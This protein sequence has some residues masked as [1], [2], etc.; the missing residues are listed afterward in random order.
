MG[1][2][3]SLELWADMRSRFHC[4]KWE[5][6]RGCWVR[7]VWGLGKVRLRK[8]STQNVSGMRRPMAQPGECLPLAQVMI[9]ESWGEP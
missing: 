9:L 1:K 7:C 6:L 8:V 2:Q 5:M 4:A 3:C